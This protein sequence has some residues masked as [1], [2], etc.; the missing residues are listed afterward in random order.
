MVRVGML[1]VQGMYAFDAARIAELTAAYL[2]ADYR[3]ELDG[4]WRWLRIG[5]P[6]PEVEAAFPD[7]T[8]FALLSAWDPHSVPRPEPEN[9]R[10]DEALHSRLA[11]GPYPLRAAFSSAPD[12]SWREPSWLVVGMPPEPLDDLTRRFG[13]LG[14]L[15]WRRGAAVRLRMDAAAPP[16]YSDHPAIDWLK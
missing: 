8:R 11:A 15:F 4:Q 12:R 14:T 9:R 6:A 2:A 1:Q 3:W 16:E 7:A 10:A 5:E 13:Q